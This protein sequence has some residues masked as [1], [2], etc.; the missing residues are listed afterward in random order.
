MEYNAVVMDRSTRTFARPIVLVVLTLVAYANTHQGDFQ[1]DDLPAIQEN[2]HLTS[3]RVFAGHLDHMVRPVLYGTFFLDHVLYGNEPAGYHFLNLLLHLGSG[4]LVYRILAHAAVEWAASIPFWTA[5]LFLIHPMATETVTYISGRASGLMSF[6]YLLAILMYLKAVEHPPV[7][8]L[9]RRYLAGAVAAFTLSLG[10]KE[11]AATLPLILALWDLVVRRLTGA[12]LRE[13]IVSYHLPFWL[14]LLTAAGWAWYHPRY[15]DLAAFS[16][17][18]RPFWDNLL[19]QAHASVYAVTLFFRPWNQNF[20]HDVPE[21]H[22]VFQWP[23]PL[24]LL[25]LGGSAAIAVFVARRLPLVS[26]GIGWFLVQL[27]PTSLIPRADLLSERN[28]YLAS[29][30]LMLV[31]ATLGS[32]FMQWLTISLPS[33]RMLRQGALSLAVTVALLLCLGT[34]QRNQL[35]QD[36]LSLWSDT[37]RKSPN[38]ARPHNN[39]GHAYAL[40]GNWDRAIE[41][42]RIASQLDPDYVRAHHNLRKAYLHEVG[43]P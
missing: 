8:H 28:L 21:F 33:L 11:T 14:V 5:L 17:H 26:F 30:G 41:E 39:L 3:W 32:R 4:L 36:Q 38:K 6:F 42:F 2:P 43:R 25:L 20:D 31:L 13:A 18:F 16:L 35:Y 19:S 9:Q 7:R 1:F 12:S 34:Y 10:S 27:L 23:L 15:T 37:V 29:F 22:S 40:Q 24:D